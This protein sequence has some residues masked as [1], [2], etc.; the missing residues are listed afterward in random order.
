MCNYHLYPADFPVMQ[1]SDQLHA[2]PEGVQL[3]QA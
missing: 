1:L 2:E 3:E